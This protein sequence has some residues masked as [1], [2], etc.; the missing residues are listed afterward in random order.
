MLEKK[1][2]QLRLKYYKELQL[3]PIKSFK[4]QDSSLMSSVVNE[5]KVIPFSCMHIT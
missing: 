1:T 2:L 4:T 3:F 5:C